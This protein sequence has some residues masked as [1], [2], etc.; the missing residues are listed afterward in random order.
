MSP[1][2]VRTVF[3]AALDAGIIFPGWS[4]LLAAPL[5]LLGAFAAGYLKRKRDARQLR[6]NF[7]S[8]RAELNSIRAVIEELEGSLSRL[9]MSTR[10]ARRMALRGRQPR[11]EK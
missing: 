1:A 2:Q 6:E 5:L 11:L 9:P 10:P 7:R 8:V 4:Y 3:E